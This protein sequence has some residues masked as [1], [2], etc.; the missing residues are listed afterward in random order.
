MSHVY[1]QVLL[2]LYY[3]WNR[4]PLPSSRQASNLWSSCLCHLSSQDYRYAPPRPAIKRLKH[5]AFDKKVF[6]GA[7]RVFQSAWSASWGQ[8]SQHCF[9]Y[10]Q[11]K[12]FFRCLPSLWA[13]GFH[14]SWMVKEV[15]LIL[16]IYPSTI[17][18]A[19]CLSA[20][21][22]ETSQK[23]FSAPVSLIDLEIHF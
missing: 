19:M 16:W 3:V 15:S 11:A 9:N 1:P 22:C 21:K 8:I 17:G 6:C 14:C 23:H 5:L 10:E 13:P 7:R 4:V 12:Q 20:Q 2:F 18:Q